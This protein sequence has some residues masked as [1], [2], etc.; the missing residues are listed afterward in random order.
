MPTYIHEL[1][2]WPQFRWDANAL[3]GAASDARL[4]Q[5]RFLGRVASLGFDLKLEAEVRSLV[6]EA[7]NTSAIEGENLDLSHVRSSVRRRLGIDAEGLPAPDRREDGVV[8]MMLDAT[9]SCDEPLTSERLFSWHRQLFPY[10]HGIKVGGYR[11]KPVQVVSGALGREKVHFEGLDP[12]RV[13]GE[14]AGFLDWLNAPNGGDLVL[15][16]GVAHLWFVTIHPFE[17]GNGRIA[18]AITD[19]LLAL[20]DGSS[21]RFYSLSS[22]IL[23]ERKDYYERLETS[24]KRTLDITSW[25]QW[26][27]ECLG[28]SIRSS[29]QRLDTILRKA[30]FW[31]SLSS[32]PVNVRQRKV[33]NRLLDGFEGNMTSSRWASIAHCSH[34]TALRDIQ[35]LVAKR[36]LIKGEA[37]GRSTSYRLR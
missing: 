18:R 27:L 13:V 12:A 35:E 36:V 1:P 17:D 29:E 30:A 16:A 7:A 3:L 11:D 33:L 22:Q 5:G 4:Q 10:G 14:M 31:D 32:V 28:R 26:F 19:R 6:D 8:A 23:I 15:N 24:Q 34:D 2:D 9:Q 21:Q 37:S 20:S 25:L